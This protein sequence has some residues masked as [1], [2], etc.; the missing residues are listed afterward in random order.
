M[1]EGTVTINCFPVF[2]SNGEPISVMVTLHNQGSEPQNFTL[3]VYSNGVK[4]ADCKTEV[5]AGSQDKFRIIT[6]AP[7]DLLGSAQR[8]HVEAV[9]VETGVK[10]EASAMIPPYQPEIF[11]SFVSFASFS[12]TVMTYMQ[13]MSYFTS[14]M[15]PMTSESSLNAG[16]VVSLSLIGLLIFLELG[17]PAYGKVGR[18]LLELRKRYAKETII[19]SSIFFSMVLTKVIMILYGI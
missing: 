18:R 4:T 9:N 7:G 12:S 14:V 2:P 6:V 3:S 10:H 16:V 1:S 13:S 5:K 11:S 19:L 15:T 8:I 17:D